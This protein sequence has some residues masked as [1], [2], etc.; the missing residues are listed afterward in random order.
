[1]DDLELT[2]IDHTDKLEALLEE[3]KMLLFRLEDVVIPANQ[4]TQRPLKI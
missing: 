4:A 2:I 1:M 3:N